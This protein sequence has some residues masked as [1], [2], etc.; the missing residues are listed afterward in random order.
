MSAAT[1]KLDRLEQTLANIEAALI[2]QQARASYAV[3]HVEDGK[4]DVE[5]FKRDYGM[6]PRELPYDTQLVERVHYKPAAHDEVLARQRE[7]EQQLELLKA[8]QA[9][10]RASNI[11][12]QLPRTP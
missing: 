4:A 7:I 1:N 9:R 12:L 3:L 8:E 2:P 11:N 6:H 5:R 10:L